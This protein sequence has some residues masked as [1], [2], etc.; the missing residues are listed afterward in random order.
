MTQTMRSRLPSDY[1][2]TAPNTPP[3]IQLTAAETLVLHGAG[4]ESMSA[5]QA[6]LFLAD[7]AHTHGDPQRAT[8]F[9]DFADAHG[10]PMPHGS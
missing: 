5:R 6:L 9:T 7:H 8:Y 1:R 4:P 2:R 10:G 3:A